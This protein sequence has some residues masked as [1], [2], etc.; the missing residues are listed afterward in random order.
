MVAHLDLD[1][2]K[3]LPFIKCPKAQTFT[4]EDAIISFAIMTE[5]ERRKYEPTLLHLVRNRRPGPPPLIA[6]VPFETRSSSGEE[7]NFGANQGGR[8]L[9]NIPLEIRRMIYSAASTKTV[10]RLMRSCKQVYLEARPSLYQNNPLLDIASGAIPLCLDSLRTTSNTRRHDDHGVWVTN[11]PMPPLFEIF[12]RRNMSELGNTKWSGSVN[13]GLN[14]GTIRSLATEDWQK[15]KTARLHVTFHT[16]T[17]ACLCYWGD[18]LGTTYCEDYHFR[19]LELSLRLNHDD[20][21]L[22]LE[23]VALMKGPEVKML[24]DL[25]LVP[26]GTQGVVLWEDGKTLSSRSAGVKLIDYPWDETQ[27][28]REWRNVKKAGGMFR[29]V[30]GVINAVVPPEKWEEM[31]ERGR[32]ERWIWMLRLVG[33]MQISVQHQTEHIMSNGTGGWCFWNE[34]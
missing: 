1:A 23:R 21:S 18:P 33:S 29:K 26:K 30:V 13:E 5:R 7:L 2:L 31:G 15:V 8:F 28:R 20:G 17:L 25:E 11:L 10:G 34:E 4:P 3:V 19:E 27:E 32:R 6:T 12:D 14:E 22:V 9:S 16:D 24:V